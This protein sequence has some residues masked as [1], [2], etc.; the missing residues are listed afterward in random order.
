M[1][2][3]FS[4]TLSR[5]VCGLFAV[6]AA[7][8]LS[9][10]APSAHAQ[11]S[12]IRGTITNAD[13]T[14]IPSVNVLLKKAESGDRVEGTSTNP[15][16]TFR[17]T[18]VA[19]GTYR[20]V[21]SAV[22]YKKTTTN[23]TVKEGERRSVSLQIRAKEY[24]L[25]EVVVSA[26]RTRERVGSL[27]SSVSV[28]NSSDLE[29][30]NSI[31]GDLG[32]ILSQKVPGLA[33]SN[34][35]LSDFGQ[36]LRGRSPLIMIDGIPQTTP[37]RD[38]ARSL[39]T[40]SPEIIKRVEVTRGANAR[41]GYGATGGAINLITKDPTSDFE[42]TT[43]IGIRGSS[44]DVQESFTGRLH[45]S[46]SGQTNGIGLVASGS[47]E[48]WGQFFD[49]RENLI[50]QDPRGQGGLAGADEISLFGKANTSFAASQKLTAS[51]QFYSLRQDLQYGRKAGTY[52]ETA[53][54]A[55]ENAGTLPTKDPGTQNLAG[56]IRYEHENL[57]NSRVS[58]QAYVQ[59]F[60]TYFGYSTRIPNG[61]QSFVESTKFGLRLDATTPLGLTEGSQVLWGVDALRDRTAQPIVDGRTFAPEMT[62]T[63]A[64]PFAQLR[65]PVGRRLTLRGGARYEA[66]SID[67]VDFTT[68]RPELDT[69]GDGN[70]D[71]RNDV[72][73]GTL[74]Y[75]DIAFN[76]GAVLTVVDPV[77][78]FVSFEQGFAAS[79][80]GRVLRSTSAPSVERLN[81]EAKTVNSY[82]TG[83]RLNTDRVTA[84][85]TGY[86][87]T[88]ELGSSFGT[89]FEIV[90][91]PERIYG[92]EVTSDVQVADPVTVGGTFSWL[93][94][95]SDPDEDDNFDT[96]LGGDRIPPEKIT[97]YVEV[98]PLDI[99]TGRLQVMYSGN[100]NVFSNQGPFGQGRVES[101]T[102]VDLSSRIDVG[103][104]MLKV[105][106]NNLLDNYYFPVRSQFAGKNFGGSS[107]TPGRGRNVSLSYKVTL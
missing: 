105:G 68:L 70:P 33:P 49:G 95:K 19:P 104:G 72:E 53:T 24:G 51:I 12:R 88:S 37:L 87:T 78:V 73:G 23:V 16:G 92:V 21:A 82:E 106:I 99:W 96:P 75:D 30:Q 38:G 56:K 61:G 36:T 22:G 5:T 69:D 15:N 58:A 60:E 7:V 32:A 31:T 41:Y 8:A 71:K 6:L 103:P 62:Q 97:G 66:L 45:Q 3:S 94:G 28:L 84:T 48:R 11:S 101:Y 76:A 86:Y 85:A 93:K 64:A 10:A 17:F 89:D 98:S 63:S 26:T 42:A 79:E 100:R 44:A 35:S 4:S 57:L 81:P 18:N 67:V 65:I 102:L 77:D 13:Q 47:Y 80:V 1:P 59:D 52:G 25:E 83:L 2:C 46:V 43:E 50:A 91:S 20:L 14:P 90:R 29:T 9:A 40:T 74:T 27:A 55:T 107:Y 34:E 54:S 39:R